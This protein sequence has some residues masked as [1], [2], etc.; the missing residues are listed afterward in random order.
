MR[1]LAILALC[2]AVAPGCQAS[3]IDRSAIEDRALL[4]ISGAFE[5][6]VAAA[7]RHPALQ[8]HSGWIGN[9]W[10]NAGGEERL[11]LCYQWQE[12]VYQEIVDAVE[13][14]EWDACGVA[15]NMETNHEH[16]AV[17]VY[18]PHRTR[19]ERIL[20][21]PDTDPAYVLDAW[22]RGRPDIYTMA[23]WLTLTTIRVP[24]QLE[25][26]PWHEDLGL[27]FRS[28]DATY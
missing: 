23:D 12:W 1:R 8:W 10:V 25:E 17:V 18:D 2:V 7:R 9:L 5:D 20:E 27:P 3:P 11:G 22:R 6:V 16:H 21:T 19:R 4:R 15:V 24:P 28:R 13:S 14:V 26:L